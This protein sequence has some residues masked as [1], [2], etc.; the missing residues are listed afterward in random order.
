MTVEGIILAAGFSSRA[1]SFK[2]GWLLDGKPLIRH[3][4]DG[5]IDFCSRIFV[6]GGHKIEALAELTQDYPEVR[7]VFNK[8][9]SSGMFSSVKEGIKHLQGDKFFLI[10]GDCPLVR[11]EVYCRLLQNPGDIVIPTFQGRK[12]HPV[13]IKTTLAEEVIREPEDSNLRNFIRR[14]GFETIAVA[15]EGILLDIDTEVAY[16]RVKKIR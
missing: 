10:P 7:V 13:L 2:M 15:D 16:E 9:Y 14:K 3:T 1:G 5:M 6:V 12:G 4:I 8:D 11:K